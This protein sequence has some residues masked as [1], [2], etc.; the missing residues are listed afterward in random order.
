[1]GR[2]TLVMAGLALLV[3]AGCGPLHPL[4]AGSTPA[5]TIPWKALPADLTPMPEPSPQAWPVPP[6]TPACTAGDLAGVAIGSQGATGHVIASFAFAGT[7]K[8]DCF[9]DGT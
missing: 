4:A 2:R 9:V 6:G 5:G 7:G 1:M 3:V 8:A